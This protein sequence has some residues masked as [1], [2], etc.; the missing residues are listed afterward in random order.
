MPK[1]SPL[2][3]R[4]L[5]ELLREQIVHEDTLVNQRLNWL[6]LSQAFLFAAFT[7]T[8]TSTTLGP[9]WQDWLLFGITI[10]GTF[11]N[12]SV[13]TG[14]RAA[15]A[16][17]K[18]LRETWYEVNGEEKP[19]QKL[20]NGF[21]KI[22]WTGKPG[23]TAIATATATPF[24]I[25]SVWWIIGMFIVPPQLHVISKWILWVVLTVNYLQAATRMII[26]TLK[27]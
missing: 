1:Q 11:T 16:S 15:Y 20:I 18:N 3:K 13:F 26:S 22:T 2:T 4:E 8:I 12:I 14:L 7:S 6:L 17:L 25:L 21:P 10:V 19:G 23:Q 24:I 9:A 5:F 27:N